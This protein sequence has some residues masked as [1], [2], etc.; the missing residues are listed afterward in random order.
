MEAVKVVEAIDEVSAATIFESLTFRCERGGDVIEIAEERSGSPPGSAFT[1]ITVSI[2][3][4]LG[5]TFLFQD[6]ALSL[7]VECPLRSIEGKCRAAGIVV[8]EEVGR[9]R[10]TVEAGKIELHAPLGPDSHDLEVSAGDLIFDK[11][12]QIASWA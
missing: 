2:R 7:T 4:G 3:R 5:I 9:F 6:N 8:R 11:N 10:V 12:V 1:A